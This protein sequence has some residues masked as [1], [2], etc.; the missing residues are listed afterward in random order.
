M[1]WQETSI[2]EVGTRRSIHILL[3]QWGLIEGEGETREKQSS[4][5]FDQLAMGTG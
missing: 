3:D 1:S 5:S 2:E 4:H